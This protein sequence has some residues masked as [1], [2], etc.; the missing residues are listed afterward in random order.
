MPNPFPREDQRLAKRM[1]FLVDFHGIGNRA[2]YLL[3][4]N[5]RVSLTACV[6]H[7]VSD[8]FETPP[9][10]CRFHRPCGLISRYRL[11]ASATLLAVVSSTLS[12]HRFNPQVNSIEARPG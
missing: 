9:R 11:E 4:H 6:L 12:G 2:G 5:C 1:D 3:A 7:R 8:D 10:P